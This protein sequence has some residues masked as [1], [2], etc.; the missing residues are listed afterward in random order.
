TAEV[1]SLRINEPL[2]RS[3]LTP[4]FVPGT[5]ITDYV[6]GAKKEYVVDAT[7]AWRPVAAPAPAA[8]AI[9]RRVPPWAWGAVLAL[10]FF[11]ILAVRA[12]ERLNAERSTKAR[13]PG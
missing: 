4:A 7:G 12:I 13:P 3:A 11:V 10:V 8:E 9:W 2:D 6:R 1:L 5:A